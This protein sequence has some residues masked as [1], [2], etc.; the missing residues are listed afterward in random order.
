MREPELYNECMDVQEY[1]SVCYL[2]S[3]NHLRRCQHG[4]LDGIPLAGWVGI[5]LKA[6]GP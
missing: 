3:I 5:S 1:M 6:V 4:D 2:N